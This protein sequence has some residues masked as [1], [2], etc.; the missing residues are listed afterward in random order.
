MPAIVVPFR[1]ENAKR[2]LT[3]APDD[4][5]TVLAEAMLED[6]LAACRAVGPTT[7]ATEEEGQ[8]AAVSAALRMIDER[9]ILVVNADLP[10]A[11]PRD[12]LTLLGALPE[13]GLALV[14]AADGTTNA[15]A[16]AARH[17]FAPLYGPGSAERFRARATRLG[18]PSAT[19]LIPNLADDVD[20]LADLDRL[21]GRLGPRTTA[22]LEE[23][24][25]G[26]AR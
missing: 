18:V 2:R 20:T 9:P 25:A 12:L 1:A 23:L 14:E 21:E 3:P 7:L 4:V 22:A 13:G 15:L 10:C 5:R 24:R 19:P 8:G 17:L 26:L 6:V 11:K 16:L